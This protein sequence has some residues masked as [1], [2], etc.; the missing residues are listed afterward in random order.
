MM[1]PSFLVSMWTRV[2]AETQAHDRPVDSGA[3]QSQ[4]EGDPVGTPAP[5]GPVDGDRLLLRRD[6]RNP[7]APGP[8]GPVRQ[9]GQ[10]LTREPLTPVG[11]RRQRDASIGA[12][13][14]HRCP[15]RDHVQRPCAPVRGQSG[16]RVIVLR[17]NASLA[18]VALTSTVPGEAFIPFPPAL[19]NNVVRDDI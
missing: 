7:E 12:R 16:V 9:S 10:A 13:I 11:V 1:R 19:V 14:G 3:G 5:F 6:E 4:H 8:A 2:P 17:P 18:S 15:R